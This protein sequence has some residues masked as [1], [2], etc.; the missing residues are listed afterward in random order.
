M[1]R[2]CV[3][4][5]WEFLGEATW[6]PYLFRPPTD[7][8]KRRKGLIGKR[9][10]KPRK[11]GRLKI[12]RPRTNRKRPKTVQQNAILK[13]QQAR[14]NKDVAGMRYWNKKYAQHSRSQ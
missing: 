9:R 5:L 13:V 2:E 14:R 11:V 10:A 6:N 4:L 3:A 1:L 12:P 7:M 8:E